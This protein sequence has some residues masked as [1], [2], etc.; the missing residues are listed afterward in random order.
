[1]LGVEPPPLV[2]KLPE[3]LATSVKF[4]QPAATLGQAELCVECL[5]VALAIERPAAEAPGLPPTD[6]PDRPLLA[7]SALDT[8][9]RSL[10]GDDVLLNP[11]VEV[12]AADAKARAELER[13]QFAAFDRASDNGNVKAG[14]LSNIPRS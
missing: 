1:M 12:L 4:L 11:G 5:G 14:D 10:R 8:H 13:P 9:A 7:L 3:R 2:K 6:D